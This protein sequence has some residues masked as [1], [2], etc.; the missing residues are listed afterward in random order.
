M[1]SEMCIRDRYG[2]MSI[3]LSTYPGDALTL[4][5]V[6]FVVVTPPLVACT[7]SFEEPAVVIVKAPSRAPILDRAAR[8]GAGAANYHGL[9]V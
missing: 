8:G 6:A 2:V 4:E 1:G 3:V 5:Y 9:L 7:V